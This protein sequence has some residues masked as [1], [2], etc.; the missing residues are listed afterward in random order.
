VIIENQSAQSAPN[1]RAVAFDYGGVLTEPVAPGLR[2]LAQSAGADI[3]E[4]ASFLF[5]AYADEDGPLPRLERGEITLA[6]LA[7]WGRAAGPE[8]GWQ[9]ELGSMVEWVAG[10]PVRPAMLAYIGGLRDRGYQTALVTNTARE[11]CEHWRTQ[12]AVDELFDASVVSCDV[13]M[14][15]PDPRIFHLMLGM[16]GR[17]APED[18]LFVDDM[19]ENVAGARRVGMAAI[20]ADEDCDVTIRRIEALLAG[21]GSG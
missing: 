19:A 4:L 11:F 15:K 16:L 6:K 5:G 21:Q 14:R 18:V 17:F 10:L 20:L 13:G 8:R 7:Q 1:L 2:E 9:L 12:I 3:A